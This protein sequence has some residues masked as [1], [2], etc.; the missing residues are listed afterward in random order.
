GQYLDRETGLHYNT[1]RF[2]DPD[3]GRFIQPDPIGLA[4]GINLHAYASNPLSWIDPWGLSCSFNGK[5]NRWRNNET[6]RF[7][8]RPASPSELVRNGKVDYGD[9]SAWANQNRLP[10]NW[11]PNTNK[12][13]SGGFKYESPPYSAHGHGANPTAVSNWPTSNAA[14]GP[15]VSIKGP[16]G[17]FRTDGTWGTFGSNPNAAHIPLINS[18]F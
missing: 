15:T 3:I 11:T 10:N 5:S 16:A 7:T 12:F 13:P 14:L 6:G 9:L 17:N 2:Y 18:P 8:T 4:G 1:F